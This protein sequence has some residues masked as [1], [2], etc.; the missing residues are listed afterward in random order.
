MPQSRL[1]IVLFVI[2]GSKK[3]ELSSKLAFVAGKPSVK[4]H[5]VKGLKNAVVVN[6]YW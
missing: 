6:E 3:L 5:L 1:N 4:I 2:Q